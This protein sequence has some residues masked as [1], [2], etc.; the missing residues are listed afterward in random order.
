MKKF[1]SLLCAL[2]LVFSVSAAPVPAKTMPSNPKALQILPTQKAVDPVIHQPQVKKAPVERTVTSAPEKKSFASTKAVANRPQMKAP[3]AKKAEAKKSPKFNLAV[4][5]RLQKIAANTQQKSLRQFNQ[6]KRVQKADSTVVP[7]YNVADALAACEAG[8]I[9][10]GDEI[11]VYGIITKLEFKGKNFAKY[12]SVNIYVADPE[13]REGVFEF[14]NCYSLEADTFRTSDP[15]F[16]ATSTAW[17]SFESVTDGN[18]VTVRVGDKVVARGN[19]K[20]YNTTHELNTGC[21]L[22][23]IKTHHIS[24]SSETADVTWDDNCA[25]EGWWQ[26]QAETSDPSIYFSISNTNREVAAGEY[27]WEDLDYNFTCVFVNGLWVYFTDGYCTVSIDETDG[28]RVLVAGSFIGEDGDTYNVNIEYVRDP[29]EPGDFDIAIESVNSS[30]YAEDNDV[31]YQL[32]ASNCTLYL[33]IIVAEGMTDVESGKTYTTEDLLLTYCKVTFDNVSAEIVSADFT[34]TTDGDGSI[35][36]SGTATDKHGRNFHYSYEYAP[37]LGDADVDF[38]QDYTTIN[39]YDYAQL[40]ENLY[41]H[42][43]QTYTD[44]TFCGIYFITADSYVEPG[45]YPISSSFEAG[46]VLA[47]ASTGNYSLIASFTEE[48]NFTAPY[49]CL[50]DGIVT[51]TEEQIVVDA[52][53]TKGSHISVTIPNMLPKPAPV[54]TVNDLA[55]I[56]F[57][58][59][60]DL[61]VAFQF[62]E[63]VCNDVV[64]VGTHAVDGSGNWIS[65]PD[66]LPHFSSLAAYGFDGWYATSVPYA[67]GAQGK[68]VQLLPDGSFDWNYQS[69][70]QDAWIYVGGNQAD[71]TPGYYGEANISYP[72]AGAYIYEIAYWKGHNTPCDVV[73]ERVIVSVKVPEGVPAAGVEI[74]GS[75]DGWTGTPME[76]YEESDSWIAANIQ[77]VASDEFKFREAGTWENEILYYDPDFDTWYAMSN[78]NFGELWYDATLG[79]EPCKVVELDFS[80]ENYRWLNPSVEPTGDTIRIDFQDPMVTYQYY[81]DGDWYLISHNDNYEVALDFFNYNPESPVGS[82]TELNLWN[83]Y[84][85]VATRVNDTLWESTNIKTAQIEVFEANNRINLQASLFCNDGNVYEVSMFR[86]KAV[87]TRQEELII[88]NAD[89]HVYSSAWQIL[90]YNAARDRYLSIAAYSSEVAGVYSTGTLATDYCYVGEFINDS[91]AI[92]YEMDD[93]AISVNY[94]AETGI[95]TAVGT[96]IASS[97]EETV[98]FILN[99]SAVLYVEPQEDY[100]ATDADFITAFDEYNVTDKGGGLFRVYSVNENNEYIN[101]YLQ[102]ADSNATALVPGQYIVSAYGEP[103]TVYNGYIEG[104]T[105]YG[106]F[107]C[108]LSEEGY[109]TV[110]LW[111]FNDGMVEVLEDGTIIV[112]VVNTHGRVINASLAAPTPDPDYDAIDADFV[113]DFNEYYIYSTYTG[114]DNFSYIY[115]YGLND[116]LQYIDFAFVLPE[117]ATEL[118]PGVYPVS[119][120]GAHQTVFNGG[121]DGGI[122]GSFAAQLVE[123]DSSLYISVPLWFFNGGDVIVNNDLSITVRATNTHGRAINANLFPTAE[124]NYCGDNLTWTLVNGVLTIQGTGDMWDNMDEVWNTYEITSV[125][126]PEGLTYIGQYA[127]YGASITEINFPSTLLTIGFGA[128]AYTNLQLV[129]F[130]ENLQLINQ[131]AFAYCYDLTYVIAKGT[132]TDLYSNSFVGSYIC[133]VQAPL[134]FFHGITSQY[135]QVAI[136]TA[137]YPQESYFANMRLAK[138]YLYYLDLSG[139]ESNYISAEAFR[140]CY[141]LETVILPAGLQVL[142]QGV[143]QECKMLKN[144]VFPAALTEIGP[145]AFEDC[146]SLTELNFEAGSQLWRVGNWAFYNCHNLQ[147]IALPEGVVSIGDGAFY[148]CVYAQT[149]NLPASVTTIGDNAFALCTRL[150]KMEVNA[151]LPPAIVDKT[152]FEVSREAPVYVPDESVDIYLQDRLWSELNIVGRSHMKEGMESVNAGE[153]VQK[154]VRDGQLFIIRGDRTFTTT[155]AEVK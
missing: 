36:I 129:E 103:Q 140:N 94:D 100:D 120:S 122:Y 85:Y 112:G 147:S 69:G 70:D 97:E 12:G 148:G 125:I 33:D 11:A 154:V 13:G 128:F 80:G 88:E 121:Y 104:T 1:I 19:Y 42:I 23:D 72:V 48:Y 3:A 53:N 89:L 7:Q 44:Q 31:Y 90:G 113:A 135:V 141:N 102:M 95:A 66:Q 152:F 124:L 51:V 39:Y 105:I 131:Y 62:D 9:N 119:N 6:T 114:D 18:G 79:G 93:A 45:V 96:L 8:E 52:W 24:L 144:I 15:D 130:P 41:Y 75:F 118:T 86:E 60:N 91:T 74:I 145:S 108:Q 16:D 126:L 2:T 76:Y 109:I 27:A 59:E 137:G 14:F 136:I 150:N 73:I 49:W 64:F 78:L 54:P 28:L 107:A 101:F 35:R 55:L 22:T 127:F 143:F 10:D 110:P 50:V 63:Q 132:Y 151:V 30:F 99:V 56:G 38:S 83:Y 155:G 17:A 138:Q 71:V 21:Y 139:L 58:V 37:Y 149:M 92:W 68:P 5:Q 65:D 123:E 32:I 134:W 98:E 82:Y 84:C 153:K 116:N 77:A 29:V 133:Y 117:G 20:L 34:K 43:I 115:L 67:E 81:S 25:S 26:I 106:S 87:P 46:T 61:V 142:E 47:S 57:D 40:D 111:L 146:R 4:P